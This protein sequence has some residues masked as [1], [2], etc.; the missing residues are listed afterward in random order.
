[1]KYCSSTF[2]DEGK[3][4]VIGETSLT[5]I[6]T[7]KGRLDK[8]ESH[9]EATNRIDHAI[10]VMGGLIIAIDYSIRT[11]LP[12][13]TLQPTATAADSNYPIKPY[14]FPLGELYLE[15]YRMEIPF[16]FDSSS[17]TLPLPL[18][19]PLT[20]LTLPFRNTKICKN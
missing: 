6:E 9:A 14:S 3:Y 2:A 1:M 16:Y 11:V 4:T 10:S 19:T 18:H 8:Y 7:E 13:S 20:Q 17:A 15:R 5:K 12:L